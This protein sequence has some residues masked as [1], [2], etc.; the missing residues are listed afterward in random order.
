METVVGCTVTS[1]QSHTWCDSLGTWRDSNHD[2]AAVHEANLL[3]QVKHVA[4]FLGVAL[5][6]ER[7]QEALR[8]AGRYDVA[9][10]E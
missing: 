2:L 10:V 8:S 9:G 5:S 7:L 6:A 4:E 1:Y 3:E